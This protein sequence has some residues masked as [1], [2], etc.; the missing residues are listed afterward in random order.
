MMMVV[1]GAWLQL[2]RAEIQALSLTLSLTFN[3]CLIRNLALSEFGKHAS[4]NELPFLRRLENNVLLDFIF[5]KTRRLANTKMYVIRNVRIDYVTTFLNDL[6]LKILEQVQNGKKKWNICLV[7]PSKQQLTKVTLLSVSSQIAD[8]INVTLPISYLINETLLPLAADWETF[9]HGLHHVSRVMLSSKT[10]C[11]LI[12]H[13]KIIKYVTGYSAYTQPI[14]Y[15]IAVR[16][17]QSS[18]TSIIIIKLQLSFV[19][20][21]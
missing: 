8:S 14:P 4:V 2:R 20:V 3:L 7:P 21:K 15:S 13:Y 17:F 16:Q 9:C 6:R 10:W 12:V 5:F 18:V 19:S 1:T 11:V